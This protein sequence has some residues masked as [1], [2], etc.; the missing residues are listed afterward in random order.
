MSHADA[1]A[2]L[3]AGR[4]QAAVR[5]LESLLRHEPGDARAWFLLGACRHALNDLPAAAEAFLRSI[6]LDPA[7]IETH[8]AYVS[9][10]RAAGS[11]RDALGAILRTRTRFGNDPRVLYASAL[12]YEDLGQTEHALA[13]YDGALAVA[14]DLEDARHNR[15][16]LLARLGRFVDGEANQRLFVETHPASTRAHSGLADMLLA[17]GSFNAALEALATVQQLSP[18]DVSA[19]VRQGVALS[20][21]RRFS[22]ARATFAAV[23]ARDRKAV[24]L[25]L[26]RIAPGSDPSLMLSPENLFFWQCHLALER[27]DWSSWNACAGELRRLPANG[28]SVVEPAVAFIAFHLPL[29]GEER[30]AVARHIAAGIE[31]RTP[32][33]PPPRKKRN[34]RVRVGILSPDFREHLNAYL[35]LPLFELLDRKRIE[36]YAY[37]PS[38]DDR[39]KIRA[40]LVASADHFRDL[41]SKSDD[42]A[43]TAIRSDDIDILVDAAGHT[44]GGRF[45]IT[46]RRPARLQVL[47]LGF[48]GSLGS[49]RVDYAITD[50]VV[51]GTPEEWSERLVFLPHTYYLYDFRSS[52]PQVPIPRK[53]Y[54]LPDDGFVYCA[55]HKAEKISPDAFALWMRILAQV[56]RSVLWLLA[57]PDA[58]QRNL[59]YAAQTHGLDAA[60]IIFAPFDPR[61]LYLAR[62][63]HGDLLL[64]AIHHSAMTTS[65]DALAAGLP[66]LTLRGSTMASRAG[67]SLLR[68]AGL[69][70]LVAQDEDAYVGLAVQLANDRERLNTYR[71]T[72]EARTG[73]LFDT[74]SRVREIEAALLQMWRQYEQRH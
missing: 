39:S 71:R 32:A 54:E 30:H 1:L 61:D 15:G 31:S 46:A 69:P 8:L 4:P 66:V 10:L 20:A 12:C 7:S 65:C 55:F 26:Q 33:L 2:H 64:D 6:E 51:G 3:Q 67:E 38:A 35:L 22:E 19:Y 13:N 60:R 24:E 11:S 50:R 44:T 41:E 16:L 9:V 34:T 14:P 28:S 52:V 17:Q 47:Y 74:E 27:C 43:A 70:E 29:S 21:L 40:R 72:L 68:A 18:G 63:R 49:T 53:D 57:L 25:Y 37:S 59:R 42:D 58:A 48:A 23:C 5:L 36:L 56:P 73:P 45:G 62:Q